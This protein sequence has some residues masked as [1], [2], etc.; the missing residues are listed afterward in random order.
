[1][2]ATEELPADEHIE[3]MRESLLT[4]Y[5]QEGRSFPWRDA[6]EPWAILVLE[7]MSQQTQLDRI[8]EPW[9]AF[10]ERWPTP[11]ALADGPPAEIIAFWSEH[12]LGYNRRAE[13]L[14]RAATHIVDAWGGT[15]R[16]D[17]AELQE[18]TGVGPYTAHALAS[19]A[20]ESP[21]AVVD[22]N[23]ERVLYRV[24]G[25]EDGVAAVA[26][27][28]LPA[29]RP[30][31]WNN[32]VMDLGAGVCTSNPA[33]DA[34][35]C[36]WREQCVAYASGTFDTPETATQSTFEGS[37]RQYRGRIVRTLAHRGPL[38]LDTLGAAI[39]D[40]YEPDGDPG[41]VWLRD[42]LGD[43]ADDGLVALDTESAT[44]SLP[45]RREQA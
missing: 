33:C 40:E 20:F 24:L 22:T 36:P 41:R 28:L 25:V 23:V 21:H 37:R 4:W 42:V 9:A 16:E 39:R 34:A 12:S 29:D 27:A 11:A 31:D 35:P 7:V 6:E 32:A 5:E 30:A 15:I 38:E 18:L 17:P 10:L 13:Y 8:E 43:L 3:A 44:V 26:D 1:M 2:A 14:H 19:F 45:N